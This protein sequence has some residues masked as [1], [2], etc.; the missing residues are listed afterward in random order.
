[1]TNLS[2][3]VNKIAWLRNAREGSR[4]NLVELSQ[5]IIDAGA[6]GI[7]VHPRP[8]LRHI[9][10]ND[11]SDLRTLT[12]TNAIELNIEGNPSSKSSSIYPGFMQLIKEFRPEQCTFV[13]DNDHQ[14]T[15]DHGWNLFNESNGLKEC[16]KEANDL[17]IRVSLFMD[18]NKSQIEK[19]K[20]IGA[21]RIELYTGPYADTFFDKNKRINN[22]SA[23]SDASLFAKSIDL[24]VNA[25]HDLDQINLKDFLLNV[26]I[27]EVSIG[28]ALIS[29]SLRDGLEVT[30]NK[31]LLICNDKL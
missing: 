30:V 16:I 18:P 22:L 14:L 20:D 10:P 6:N 2:V 29:D 15:S 7:T 26:E 19:A 5:I 28:Q 13:P 4:P 9:R 24:G 23:Y 1:M 27:D 12:K 17:G 25:G 11:V 31:Y 3:N 8:D 21:D